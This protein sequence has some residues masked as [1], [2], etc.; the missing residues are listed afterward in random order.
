MLV[1]WKAASRKSRHAGTSFKL[2]RERKWNRIVDGDTC[3]FSLSSCKSHEKCAH[4]VLFLWT[5]RQFDILWMEGAELLA[6]AVDFDE[7]SS[8]RIRFGHVI[9]EDDEIKGSSSLNMEATFDAAT[10]D[11][12][13]VWDEL[14]IGLWRQ[15][16]YGIHETRYGFRG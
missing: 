15:V 10:L 7:R 13:S 11:Q 14:N 12:G 1:V 6:V 8:S 2:I 4:E 9:I 3:N 5:A 16:Q